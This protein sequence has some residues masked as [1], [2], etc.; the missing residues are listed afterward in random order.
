MAD[1]VVERASDLGLQAQVYEELYDT[2]VVSVPGEEDKD[3]LVYSHLDTGEPTGWQSPLVPQVVGDRLHGLGASDDKASVALAL[4]ML[5]CLPRQRSRSLTFVFSGKEEAVSADDNPVRALVASGSIC[6]E[7]ALILEPTCFESDD[8]SP[9]RLG[10][11]VGCYGL[12]RVDL[13]F[14]GRQ[15]HS[16]MPERAVNAILPAVSFVERF[17]ASFPRQSPIGLDY[18][19]SSLAVGSISSV[20]QIH[21]VEGRGTI[22]GRCAVSLDFRLAP[23][24]G[25]SSREYDSKRQDIEQSL[26]FLLGSIGIEPDVEVT[27]NSTSFYGGYLQSAPPLLRWFLADGG[28]RSGLSAELM[29]APGRCDANVLEAAG[30]PCLVVGP[31]LM[32]QCHR[33]EEFVN[34][35]LA[36]RAGDLIWQGVLEWLG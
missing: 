12:Y 23:Q 7:A 20:T 16:A 25:W 19:G 13:H 24:M 4:E 10:L 8:S 14:R 17:V 28:L 9:A 30:V 2:V 29:V 32:E 18:L 35:D 22:P 6:P 21:S 1:Y 33:R 15:G 36:K 34:L 31:G 11:C 5:S 3:L 26:Q 27:L